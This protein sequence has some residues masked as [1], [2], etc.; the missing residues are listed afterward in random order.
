MDKHHAR[1]GME[2]AAWY[3]SNQKFHGSD[4]GTKFALKVLVEQYGGHAKAVLPEL[5][6]AAQYWEPG[7]L[8]E[9]EPSAKGISAQIRE[10]M[11]IIEKAQTPEWELTSIAEY[12]N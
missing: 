8:A 6:K 4:N 3:L 7:G 9:Q 12:L 2:L 10:A 1:E 11:A 5:E